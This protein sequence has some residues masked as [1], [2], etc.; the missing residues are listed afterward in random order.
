MG[1]G[2]GTG[3]IYRVNGDGGEEWT[4]KKV[5]EGNAGKCIRDDVDLSSPGLTGRFIF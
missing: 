2:R 5:S 3:T 4:R 1:E